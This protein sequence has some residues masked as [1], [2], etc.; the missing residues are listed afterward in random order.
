LLIGLLFRSR[1]HSVGLRCRPTPT[2]RPFVSFVLGAVVSFVASVF[3]IF[4]A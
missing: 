2:D 3:V 4:V 1:I